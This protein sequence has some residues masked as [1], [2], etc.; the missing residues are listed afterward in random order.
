MCRCS[1]SE[2]RQSKDNKIELEFEEAVQEEESS[3][4]NSNSSD[5]SD[6][7]NS[8]TSSSSEE[9]ISMSTGSK[10]WLL[11]GE[12]PLD[13][14]RKENNVLGIGISVAQKEHKTLKKT[15]KKTYYKVCENYYV[16]RGLKT[17]LPRSN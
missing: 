14:K 3:S 13:T 1:G 8:T 4:N 11:G 9:I 2:N 5:K 17:S 12:D 7:D 15:G 16:L 6:T 10:K